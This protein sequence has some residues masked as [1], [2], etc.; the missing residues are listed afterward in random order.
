MPKVVNGCSGLKTSS[1]GGLV[2]G[3]QLNIHIMD[4]IKV[5]WAFQGKA[6]SPK[7]VRVLRVLEFNGDVLSEPLNENALDAILGAYTVADSDQADLF[8]DYAGR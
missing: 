1:F 3:E 8:S 4:T 2:K 6:N 7:N 5:Q